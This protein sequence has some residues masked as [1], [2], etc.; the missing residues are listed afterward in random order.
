LFSSHRILYKKLQILRVLADTIV[1]ASEVE[2]NERRPTEMSGSAKK[3]RTI[4][5][6]VWTSGAFWPIDGALREKLVR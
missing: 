1:G 5:S 4:G 2:P 6:R 3:L